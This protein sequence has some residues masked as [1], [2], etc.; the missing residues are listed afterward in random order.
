MRARDAELLRWTVVAVW[1]VTAFTSL[2]GFHG[3]S[4]ALLVDA[5]I[6]DP[7]MIRLLIG[8][9][10]LADLVVGV[11]MARWP[12]RPVYLAALALMTTMTVVATILDPGLWL[13]PLG[14]LTKNLPIAAALWIL[15]GNAKR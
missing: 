15:A 11:A 7:H 8:A 4:R 5:G 6:T 14:P 9:G 3:Q 2:L 12:A 10:A 13:H 1:L